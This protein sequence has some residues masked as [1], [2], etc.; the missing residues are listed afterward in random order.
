VA[1]RGEVDAAAMTIDRGCVERR[2]EDEREDEK[3]ALWNEKR[4]GEQRR[5][6]RD[7][8]L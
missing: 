8:S 1:E 2:R 4:A 7:E 3:A 6:G 5:R